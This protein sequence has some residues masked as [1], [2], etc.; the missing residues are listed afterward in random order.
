M[1]FKIIKKIALRWANFFSLS[2]GIETFIFM[3]FVG[4]KN[5]LAVCLITI[6]LMTIVLITTSSS[7]YFRYYLGLDLLNKQEILSEEKED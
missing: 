7:G 6:G 5:T 1:K 3:L 4:Y 2:L